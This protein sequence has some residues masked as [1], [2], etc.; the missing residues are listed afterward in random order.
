MVIYAMTTP[1]EVRFISPAHKIPTDWLQEFHQCYTISCALL[2][3]VTL[4]TNYTLSRYTEEFTSACK[5]IF[6]RHRKSENQKIRIGTAN[7]VGDMQRIS[8]KTLGTL[9]S[10]CFVVKLL[11]SKLWCRKTQHSYHQMNFQKTLINLFCASTIEKKWEVHPWSDIKCNVRLKLNGYWY[12]SLPS[13][14]FK[15]RNEILLQ[16]CWLFI[17]NRGN[18]SAK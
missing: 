18:S 10:A 3:N 2:S 5:R 15:A 9:C 7:K 6:K 14:A 8:P 12:K 11:M 4:Q 1:T 16:S 17:A 13:L